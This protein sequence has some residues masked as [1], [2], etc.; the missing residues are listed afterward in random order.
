MTS[1][2]DVI[3]RTVKPSLQ[4]VLCLQDIQ[5]ALL[6]S[7]VQCDEAPIYPATFV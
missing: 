7:G 2:F 5:I 1:G 3:A 6:K 4:I